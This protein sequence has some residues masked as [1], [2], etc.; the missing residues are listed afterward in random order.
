MADHGRSG[1]HIEAELSRDLGLPSALAIGVGT[2][3]AAGIFTLSGLAVRN[4]GSAAIASFLIAA[5]VALFTALTYCEFAALYP[6]SGEGYLYA[7]RTFAPPVAWFVGW[8]LFLGYTA[9]CGFYI[10]SL[11]VYFQEFVWHSPWHQGSGLISL[12]LLTLLNTKGTKESGTFQIVVTVGKVILLIWFVAG[13]LPSVT[14]EMMVER[15]STDIVAITS[16]SA[17]VFITF[18]GFSAIA[19]SAGEVKD[20]VKNIPRAIFWSM[21]IVTVLYTAVVAVILAANL[22]EYSEAA[23]GSAARLFLGPVGGAVIVGGALFSMISAS[24][25]SIMAGSRV[26]MAMAHL[27]HL[28]AVLGRVHP[29]TRTP[30]LALIVVGTTIGLFAVALPL[31][32]L[33]HYADTVLLLALILVN[34]ALIAHRR[35]YPDMARPFRVPLVPLLPAMGIVANLYLL[36]QIAH[37]GV[38]FWL[39]I[40]T[41]LTGMA[42][43]V[44]WKGSRSEEQHMDGAPSQ[45]AHERNE[46]GPSRFRV[47]VPIANPANLD[48]F[49]DLAACVAKERGGEIVALRVVTVPEQTI[50]TLQ[51]DVIQGEAALLER[52]HDRAAQHGVPVTSLVV[53]G[54]NVAKAILETAHS[55][56]CDLIVLGWKGYT[57]TARRILGEITDTVVTHAKADILVIK[58]VGRAPVR[59][60]LMPTAGGEHAQR[61]ESYTAS[62]ARVLDGAITVCKIIPTDAAAEA[63]AQATQTLDDAAERLS[64]VERVAQ[65]VIQS[66]DVV[67]AILAESQEH[68]AI[69]IGAAGPASYRQLLM[70]T[71]PEEVARLADRTVIIVK[72]HNAVKA[73]IGRVLAA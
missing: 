72:R 46:P 17:M 29:K 73:M 8:C 36:A 62:L 2:M 1:T 5:V 21:G 68:D 34:A 15:F 71:V 24:N 20:P 54:H 22:T 57:S 44:L 39:A 26:A 38:P 60:Y 37:H 43:F 31:E 27:G 52:A 51:D 25:A 69:V 67:G 58:R 23:M 55:R 41:L 59:R 3:V 16:T 10:S 32:D 42:G 18:F 56:S 12:F 53:V 28:P 6:R 14:G 64:D 48:S 9:S 33:A 50:P 19:A 40:S 47:L 61:A 11:S 65:K 7:R 49:I 35:A 4:V 45:V 66:D 13:G 30:V 70:G 63:R